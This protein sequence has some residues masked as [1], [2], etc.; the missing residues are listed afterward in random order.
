MYNWAGEVKHGL[1]LEIG[2]TVEVLEEYSGKSTIYKL[3]PIQI[4][5]IEASYLSNL[6]IYTSTIKHLFI[7]DG[8]KKTVPIENTDSIPYSYSSYI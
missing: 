3:I 4:A 7:P 8:V 2:D 5:T 6:S 1:P